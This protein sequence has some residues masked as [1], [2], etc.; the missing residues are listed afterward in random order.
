MRGKIVFINAD[1]IFL[2][3]CRLLGSREG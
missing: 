1:N 2:G 3:D